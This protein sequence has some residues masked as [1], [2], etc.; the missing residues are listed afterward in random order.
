MTSYDAIQSAAEIPDYEESIRQIKQVAAR[1]IADADNEARL[2]FTDHFNHSYLPDFVLRWRNRPDRFVFLRASSYAE[3]IEDD[4][5]S[6][7]DKH[8][9]FVPLSKFRPYRDESPRAALDSLGRSASSSKTLVTSVPAIEAIEGPRA[10]RTGRILASYVVRGGKGLVEDEVAAAI[11]ERVETGFAGALE[12]DRVRTADAID[13]VETL[14][15]PQSIMQFT[16]LLEAA[17]ISGGGNAVEFPGG[18]SSVGDQL[19]AELLRQ[20]LAIVPETAEEFWN[21]TG[22]SVN[23]ESFRDLHL[24]GAQPKLQMM[25]RTAVSRL[26]ASRCVILGTQRSNQKNDPF[27]WQVENGALSLRGG[28]YQAWLSKVP[29]PSKKDGYF[30]NPIPTLDQLTVRAYNADLMISELGV[31]DREGISVRFATHAAQQN[32][33]FSDLVQ[34]VSVSLGNSVEV[35]H[36][37]ARVEGKPLTIEFDRS[38][39]S[40]RTSSVASL[41]VLLWTSW[42]LLGDLSDE[43]IREDFRERL[44]LDDEVHTVGE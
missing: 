3:E 1:T 41:S 5:V 17:W 39:S 30:Q 14:L 40:L 10:E 42:A 34:R 33:A 32:V 20:L 11:A 44:A 23:R 31:R 21:K 27:L 8:P 29:P 26:T 6:L 36:A 43:Y 24:V 16:H 18:P 25:M 35:D 4:V 22:N 37:V 19:S 9:I 2:F 15:D 13:A 28:G 12:S 7:A 38:T